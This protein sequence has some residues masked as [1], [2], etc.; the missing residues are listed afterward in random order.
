MDSTGMEEVREACR[1]CHQPRKTGGKQT[2]ANNDL[3]LAA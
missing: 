3:A 2:N 1:G